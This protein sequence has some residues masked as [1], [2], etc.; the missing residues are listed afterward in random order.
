MAVPSS[1]AAAKAAAA[2]GI[3]EQQTSCNGPAGCRVFPQ[4]DDSLPHIV[5]RINFWRMGTKKDFPVLAGVAVHMLCMHS[6]AC[7]SERNWSAWGQLCTKQHSRLALE[8]ARK[9]IYV[10]CNSKQFI[11]RRMTWKLVVAQGGEQIVLMT[12]AMTR[13]G[14]TGQHRLNR[15]NSFRLAGQPFHLNKFIKYL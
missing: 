14:R 1:G 12:G 6:N 5:E 11:L 8:H 7:A 10:C 13:T 9:L 2:G 15:F 3:N 4:D